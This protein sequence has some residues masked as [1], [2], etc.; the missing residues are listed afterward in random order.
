MAVCFVLA[1]LLGGCRAQPAAVDVDATLAAIQ[2]RLDEIDRLLLL[3]PEQP[4]SEAII[5]LETIVA[6]NRFV[7]EQSKRIT[8]LPSG[9]TKSQATAMSDTVKRTTKQQSVTL[10][11]QEAL[12]KKWKER[13][14]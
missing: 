9:I 2:A 3:V 8:E 4:S 12:R 11:L 5:T 7:I 10:E 6:G 1:V 14:S 13:K